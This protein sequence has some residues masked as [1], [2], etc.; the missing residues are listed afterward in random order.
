M[1]AVVS[2]RS[3]DDSWKLAGNI[4]T[5]S[6]RQRAKFYKRSIFFSFSAKANKKQTNKQTKLRIPLGLVPTSDITIII[7]VVRRLCRLCR[8][9]NAKKHN[10]KDAY[11]R[12]N[13]NH[14][15]MIGHFVIMLMS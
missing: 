11:D 8:S 6:R 2:K 15:K 7:I 13:H 4:V 3:M 14:K 10:H 5:L 9:V 12:H 1:H